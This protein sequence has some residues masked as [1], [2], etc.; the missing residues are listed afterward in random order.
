MS[1]EVIANLLDEKEPKFTYYLPK[2]RLL[3]GGAIIDILEDR[4]PKDYDILNQSASMQT[5]IKEGF[6]FV[7]KTNTAT[8]YKFNT[9][10]SKDNVLQVLHAIDSSEFDFT[11]SQTSLSLVKNPVLTIDETAFNEKILIPVGFDKDLAI[12]S[13]KR[14][15]H[16]K[17]K[18][19]QLDDISY[20][21]LLGCI[22]PKFGGAS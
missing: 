8:T 10:K 17:N 3:V 21:S 20:L 16:W 7:R 18:G 15:P 11:I 12:N 6:R 19:Y 14:I 9:E 4:K 1:N 2:P 13:L 5:L 22:N